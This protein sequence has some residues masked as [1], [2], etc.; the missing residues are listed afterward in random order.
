MRL[1]L[2]PVSG[3]PSSGLTLCFAAKEKKQKSKLLSHVILDFFS[4]TTLFHYEI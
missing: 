1:P 2:N 3:E 4:L